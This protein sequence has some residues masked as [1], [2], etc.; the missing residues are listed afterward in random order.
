MKSSVHCQSEGIACAESLPRASLAI[1]VRSFLDLA[2]C[3]IPATLP[4]PTQTSL[5]PHDGAKVVLGDLS[6]NGRES[7]ITVLTLTREA[8]TEA[9]TESITIP[10]ASS[11]SPA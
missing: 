8:V 1:V 6:S 4:C 3:A 9:R 5:Q 10:L 11:P 7:G 2:A